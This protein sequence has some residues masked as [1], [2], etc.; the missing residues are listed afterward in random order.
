MKVLV[1]Q[2]LLKALGENLWHVFL[3]ASVD[4]GNP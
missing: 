1:G 3:L 4:T 2:F